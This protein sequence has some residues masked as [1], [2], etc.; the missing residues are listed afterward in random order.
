MRKPCL[1]V[2]FGAGLAVACLFSAGA[3]EAR[4]IRVRIV[5]MAFQPASVTA[6][7][8]DVV[9][10]SNEDFVDHTATG[11]AGPFDVV[12]PAGKHRSV[13][14]K[15]AGRVPYVCRFHPT[16]GGAITVE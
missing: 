15:H 2:R 1:A 11:S 13:V 9:E 6:A 8:G 14:L 4:T 7:V 5:D 3:S 16:M 12:I 10:W